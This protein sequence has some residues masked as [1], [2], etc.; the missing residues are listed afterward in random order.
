MRR[1]WRHEDE[2]LALVIAAIAIPTVIAMPLVWLH[3]YDLK[4]KLTLTLAVLVGSGGLALAIRARVMRPLQ[5]LANLTASLRERDYAVRGRHARNDD[6]LGLA[7][8]EL[9]ELAN[10]LRAE[11]WRD[12]ETS[13]GLARVIESLDAAVIAVDDTNVVRMANRTAERLVGRR[14]EDQPLA[15]LGLAELIGVDSPR[16]IELAMTGARG[17]W[18]VR[19]SE[20]R[21]SGL[22]H[23][24]LVMTDVQ[25][26]LRAE[27]RQ[28]WQR[29]VRVLGH[30]INNSLGPISSIAETL[31]SGLQRPQRAADF[32]DDLQRGLEVIERRAAALARFMQSYA[33]LVRLP[34]PRIVRVDVA[35]WIERTVALET[36]RKVAIDPGPTLAVPG[37]PD[38]L[39]QLLINLLHNAVEASAETGGA[40]RITWT[41]APG[42]VVIV[43]DDE[44]HGVAD[45]AN[46]FVPFFTT[47]PSGSGIGLVLARQI[48]EAHGGSLVVRNRK[49]ARGAEAVI[50][51]P[52][53]AVA[54]L[55]S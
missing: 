55:A 15:D 6:A 41:V 33:R 9:A 7:M 19:P 50:T 40:V 8:L 37:D 28:A 52:I 30:E 46:L 53:R 31:R 44:G 1:P 24:L 36:R 23:R 45:T 42:S 12:E 26:A 27:E 21:F 14:L 32:D 49:S 22:P 29:L 51:L 5:T 13:A 43:I 39:D 20:V 16:T 18:E 34:P 25:H 17:T 54:S 10:Q 3:D 4:S 38:Q 35:S 48:A 2:I 11:R 47:K